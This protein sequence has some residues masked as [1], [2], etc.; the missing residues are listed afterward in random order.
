MI[1]R[2]FRIAHH[3][4]TEQSNIIKERYVRGLGYVLHTITNGHPNMKMMFSEWGY[5]I[6]NEEV[7]SYFNSDSPSSVIEALSLNRKGIHFYRLK[8]QFYYDC[9]YLTENFNPSLLEDLYNLL[10]AEGT[11]FFTK[12]SLIKTANFFMNNNGNLNVED[13]L[14][15]H[16]EE[17]KLFLEKKEIRVLIVATVSAG[18]STLINALIGRNFNKVMNG[19]CTTSICQIHNKKIDDGI[20]LTQNKF[21]VYSSDIDFFSSNDSLEVAFHF[22]SLLSDSRICLLD[23][24]GVNNSKDTDHFNITA[25]AIKSKNYDIIIF[26][27]NGQYNGT[28]D[29]NHLLKLLKDSTN[30]PI[31]FVL[32]QLDKFKSKVDDIEKMICNYYNELL[33]IGFKDPQ[34]IPLS[35]Q[36]AN[37]LRCERNLDEDEID[38]LKMMRKR[39]SKDYLD[40]QRYAGKPSNTEIEKSGIILLEEAIKKQIIKP[41]NPVNEKSLY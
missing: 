22:N 40:L 38:E 37:L 30:N 23:T 21:L 6:M 36:F 19:V 1:S 31:L 5:S 16:R 27:S 2:T 29:E 18:K 11:T 33:N 10:F 4:V 13:V 35:A 32:N 9:F 39:F 14:I 28:N 26:I 34:I 12:K 17:N 3:P 41:N 24:P 20:T 15:S 8:H 25:E 7:S